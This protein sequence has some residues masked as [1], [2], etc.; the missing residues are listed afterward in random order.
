MDTIYFIVNP[1][2]GGGKARRKFSM[3]EQILNEQKT[4]YKA[5]YTEYPGHATQLAAEALAKNYNT[6]VAVG[7]DGTV[8][9]VAQVLAFSSA[10]MGVLPFG[11]GNDF[12]KTLKIPKDPVK[13]LKLILSARPKKIDISRVNET[14]CINTSG[15]GFDVDVLEKTEHYKKRFSGIIPYLLGIIN[16]L[17]GLRTYSITVSS[18][19]EVIKTSSILLSVANG[20][21]F[22][23]G[24]QVA[25]L[26]KVDDGLLDVCMIQPVGRFKV[27]LLLTRFINGKHLK[28]K[29]VQHFRAAR[30]TV[31]SDPPARVQLDGEIIAQTPT[32]FEV[33]PQALCVF[34]P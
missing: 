23:G 3:I 9:E 25:P 34:M 28:M 6:I 27:L 1:T 18:E 29:I 5:S 33:L 30:L 15:L 22:G 32:T 26:A 16:A 4:A 31:D 10:A 17:F 24:M 13:A 2:A 14:I 11:T 7:G 19:Q 8:R 20:I 12:I 21:Y